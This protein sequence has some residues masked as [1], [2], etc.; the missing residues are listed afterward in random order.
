MQDVAKE[1]ETMISSERE[2]KIAL[3]SKQKGFTLVELVIVLAVLAVIIGVMTAGMFQS[4]EDA[5]IQAARTQI[6]KDFPSGIMRIRTMA[7]TCTAVDTA[8][9]QAR[10]LPA[11]TVW[12]TNWS[13]TGATA[14]G[15]TVSYPTA[16]SDATILADV[17]SG[18]P[19]YPA[20]PSSNITTITASGTTLTIVYRCN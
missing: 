9:L 1:T 7:N 15:V 12:G 20:D 2:S 8:K 18:I 16:L 17:A 6:M 19:R 3:G 10:G 11:T 5:K 4:Q 13:V 14:T